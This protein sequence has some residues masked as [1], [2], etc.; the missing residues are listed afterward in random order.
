MIIVDTLGLITGKKLSLNNI[1]ST[2]S[3]SWDL[4][5]ENFVI[6]PNQIKFH[7]FDWEYRNIS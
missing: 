2:C 1:S 4:V 7:E 3:L 5:D 6:Y